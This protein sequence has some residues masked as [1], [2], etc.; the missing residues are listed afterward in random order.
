MKKN[1]GIY[2]MSLILLAVLIV[3]IIIGL[4]VAGGRKTKQQSVVGIVMSGSME[5]TGWNSIQYEGLREACDTLDVRLLVKENVKEFSGQCNSAVRELVQEGA[6]MIILASYNYAAEAKEIVGE[7]PQVSFYVNSSEYH[8]KNMTSYF[9]RIYEA[10]YLA[11]IVAGMETRTNKVGY[12]AAMPNNEVNRGMNAFMLGMKRVN[13]EAELIVAW[14]GSWDDEASERKQA[15]N[16]MEKMGVDVLTCH[17][18][19][20]Y[21]TEEAQK[22]GIMAIGYHEAPARIT[23]TY[24][25]TVTYSWKPLFQELIRGYQQGRGNACENYWLGLEK[26]VIGLGEFSPRVGEETKA[27]VEQ[28]KQEILAGKDVFS[29]EIYDTEGQIRCEDNEA[30]SDTVLLEAMDWYVEGISFY[31]E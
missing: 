23:D 26:G 10:R 28:A 25:T 31:E 3:G 6:G 17:Q 20:S 27:Q 30:I 7:Y 2:R 12:V 18:N 29:G 19:R 11:G 15:E 22:A 21:V 4:I 5:D 14:S 8:D 9:L 13:P 1:E 16:L 24:L